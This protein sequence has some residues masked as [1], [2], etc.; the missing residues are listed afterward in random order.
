MTIETRAEEEAFREAAA[1]LVQAEQA[2]F[3]LLDGTHEEERRDDL[4][5][6]CELI[7]EAQRRLSHLLKRPP[8]H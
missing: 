1:S 7:H 4:E 6:V 8:S 5:R 3:W 2:A